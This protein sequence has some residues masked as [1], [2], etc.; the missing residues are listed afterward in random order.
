MSTQEVKLQA[1][2]DAIREKDGTTAPIPAR[3]FPERIRA[4]ETGGSLPDNVRT[5]TLAADPPE[6]GT[7]S[8]GGVASDGMTVTVK[9]KAE[10]GYDAVDWQENGQTVSKSTEYTFT[11]RTDRI[12]VATFVEAVNFEWGDETAVGD[13]DWWANLKIWAINATV[14]ERE[15]VIGKR[16]KVI[17]TTSVCGWADGAEIPMICI[18]ADIDGICTLTFQTEGLSPSG[19]AFGSTNAKYADSTIR[20]EAETFAD[21]CSA[22]SSIAPIT[23]LT[24]TSEPN[25]TQTLTADG[26]T[27]AKGFIPSDCEMGFIPGADYTSIKGYS[28]SYQEWAENGAKKAY[29]YY[30]DNAKRVKYI[31]NN[32]GSLTTNTSAYWDRSRSYNYAIRACR[33]GAKGSPD[34]T[35]YSTT[36]CRL[37][38]AFVIG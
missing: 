18:G 32:N 22:T 12:L 26:K 10:A 17:L 8:G 6:G 24:C 35:N 33:I 25:G 2:A 34:S 11:V 21:N 5:I 16:K 19:L 30:I 3:D 7:V 9:A 1:I 14:S 4:I 15:A 38:P 13:A 29:Q 28:I 27:T 31:S 20:I 23:K 36:S 37:S